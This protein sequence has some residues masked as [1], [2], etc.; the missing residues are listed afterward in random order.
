MLLLDIKI[1]EMQTF[2]DLKVGDKVYF[3][4]ETH[5]ALEIYKVEY[6]FPDFI[7]NKNHYIKFNFIPIASVNGLSLYMYLQDGIKQEMIGGVLY[8]DEEEALK[9]Y[10]DIL[11]L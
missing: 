2:N 8:A 6:K 10:N 11:K 4:N 7:V 3:V 1:E 9:Y 5:K